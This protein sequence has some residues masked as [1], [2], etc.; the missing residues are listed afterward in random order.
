MKTVIL[1]DWLQKKIFTVIA[2]TEMTNASERHKIHVS[3]LWV[4]SFE[5]EKVK[6]I[7]CTTDQ[8]MVLHS[9]VFS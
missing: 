4:K 2:A 8:T 1:V 9:F 3:K 7:E 5:L 6:T